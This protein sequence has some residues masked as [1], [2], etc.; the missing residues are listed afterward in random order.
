M[1]IFRKQTSLFSYGPSEEY[2]YP[3]F[4]LKRKENSFQ[5]LKCFFK[6]HLVRVSVLPL[7]TEF[8]PSFL[9]I[10]F[11]LYSLSLIQLGKSILNFPL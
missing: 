7:M 1:N 2:C 5:N 10:E 3:L 4:F 11:E 8:P 6:V 9:V